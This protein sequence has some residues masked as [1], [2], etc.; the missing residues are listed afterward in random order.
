MSKIFICIPVHNRIK[1]TF[2]CIKSICDQSY[3]NYKIII[4]DDG[5][6]DGTST[7]IKKRY[8]EIVILTGNGSLWWAG[9]TNKCVQYVLKIAKND[10]YVFT[11]N[12]DTRLETDTIEILLKN[13]KIYPNSIIGAVNVFESNGRS[14]EPSAQKKRNILGIE[15]FIKVNKWG[16]PLDKYCDAVQVDAL[17]GKGVLIPVKVFKDIG[18][19]NSDLLPHYHADTEFIYR[20]NRN[21]YKIILCYDTKILSH[22]NLSGFGTRTTKANIKEFIRSFYS[23][24]STHHIS[25]L[26]NRAKLIYGEKYLIQYCISLIGIILGFVKRYF[27]E[28]L[29]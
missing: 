27:R 16:E 1:Y 5:S 15:Y 20:A 6:T 13:A 26:K 29:R 11:L 22:Q 8:P 12:N 10:D 4:T 19:Y 2:E 25:S 17:S 24:K 28:R 21:G 9:A 23:I 18:L 7:A 3:K 14:I